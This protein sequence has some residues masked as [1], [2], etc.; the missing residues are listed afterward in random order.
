MQKI[1]LHNIKNYIQ[2]NLQM[3]IDKTGFTSD[4][5]KE[6]IAYRML[7][8][9]DC[10]KAGVCNVCGCDVP[11]RLFTNE[12]CNKERFPDIMNAEEWSIY[13]KQQSIE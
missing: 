8:C 11:G 1:N 9:S 3:I 6:Q 7:K 12:S 5:F 13:K 10:V 2:G 4:S